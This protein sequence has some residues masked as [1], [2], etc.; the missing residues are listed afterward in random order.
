M[1]KVLEPGLKSPEMGPVYNGRHETSIFG[2]VTLYKLLS[3]GLL[4]LGPGTVPIELTAC[5][6]DQYRWVSLYRNFLHQMS[7]MTTICFAVSFFAAS[8]EGQNLLLRK[9]QRF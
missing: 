4:Q 3:K 7:V 8:I 5:N 6:G 1:I 2:V 9:T